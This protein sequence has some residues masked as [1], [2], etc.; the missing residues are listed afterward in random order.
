MAEEYKKRRQKNIR[1]R[2][3]FLYNNYTKKELITSTKHMIFNKSDTKKRIIN[4]ILKREFGSLR[5]G[6]NRLNAKKII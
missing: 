5:M 3:K 6:N 4:L 1:N 2:R